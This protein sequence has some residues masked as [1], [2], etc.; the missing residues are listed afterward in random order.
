MTERAAVLLAEVEEA[1]AGSETDPAHLGRIVDVVRRAAGCRLA[2]AAVARVTGEFEV[3]AGASSDERHHD[4]LGT[5][6]S[7][8]AFEETFDE[9]RVRVGDVY[10][11]REEERRRDPWPFHRPTPIAPGTIDAGLAAWRPTDC[12]GAVF[13]DDE[14]RP[15]VWF[16]V[17][18]PL[19]GR[20]PDDA[21]LGEVSA[22]TG[23]AGEL[24]RRLDQE[25]RLRRAVQ[26]ADDSRVRVRRHLAQRTR[27][28]VVT[29][30]A[31]ALL[32]HLAVDLVYADAGADPGA[33]VHAVRTTDRAGL[34]EKAGLEVLR[35]QAR[36]RA[37]RYWRRG[38][39]SV[40]SADRTVPRDVP[41]HA[42][43]QVVAA[44]RA[45]G[46][47]SAML[48]PA[49][50]REQCLG[51]VVLLRGPD[52]PDWTDLELRAAV[53]LGRDIGTALHVAELFER[54]QR[55]AEARAQVV[56]TMAH[57]LKAP[58]T[59]AQGFLELVEDALAEAPGT[60]SP[61]AAAVRG[62]RDSGDRVQSIVDDLLLLS[63]TW[64]GGSTPSV[65]GDLVRAARAAAARCAATATTAGV[66]IHLRLP[67]RAV[68]VGIEEELLTRVVANLLVNAVRYS[69]PGTATSLVVD[70]SGDD[71]VLQVRDQGWGIAA[72]ELVRVGT[73]FFRSADPRVRSRPGAGLGLAVVGRIV[74]SGGGEVRLDSAPGAGTTACVRLPRLTEAR[75]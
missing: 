73:E 1:M 69:D 60:T 2:I 68:V 9:A 67:D 6:I 41:D 13:R 27:A 26:L 44:L 49:G 17:D 33:D 18:D 5:H 63:R 16:Q 36:G 19:D 25:L 55:Q 23:R 64:S 11:L 51:V 59:A 39:V 57:E 70:T 50:R 40:I 75:P 58:L 43:E 42:R 22:V 71:A 8:A 65:G 74:E 66:G 34:A 14:G 30:A 31:E 15:V 48:V 56:S 61:V 4:L 28:A 3:V 62:I 47:A 29:A 32:D 20:R 52:R 72:P 10:L 7:G 54:E 45:L 37:E 12:W 35:A 53:E 24:L 38:V 21:V 46:M